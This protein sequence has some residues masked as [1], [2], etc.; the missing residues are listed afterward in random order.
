MSKALKYSAVLIGLYLVV[1]FGTQSG[2]VIEHST[3]GASNV[4]KAFQ[5]RN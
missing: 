4:I 3:S 1:A 5:A 2:Q